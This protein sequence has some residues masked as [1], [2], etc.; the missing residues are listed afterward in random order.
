M[1]VK[2]WA[3]P[4]GRQASSGANQVV[5]DTLRA[6]PIDPETG[7]PHWAIVEERLIPADADEAKN[8]RAKASNRASLI[9]QGRLKP[10]AV[11]GVFDAVSRSERL[12]NEDGTPGEEVVRVYARY[13]GEDREKELVAEDNARLEAEK[14]ATSAVPANA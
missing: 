14:A 3:D 8:V 7:L 6:A 12:E 11:K 4:S 9:K 10:F 5:A 1:E 2:G 13:G